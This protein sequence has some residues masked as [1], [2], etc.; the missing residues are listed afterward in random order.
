MQNIPEKWEQT[1]IFISLSLS[2]KVYKCLRNPFKVF[3]NF[4]F[5]EQKFVWC[6]SEFNKGEYFMHFQFFLIVLKEKLSTEVPGY[7]ITCLDHMW[8]QRKKLWVF[9]GFNSKNHL[10]IPLESSYSY[11]HKI[12]FQL[13]L[14]HGN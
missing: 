8:I 10:L 12:F 9:C 3:C 11:C 7:S 13:S 5:K 1:L 2:E 14:C 4:F 6:M